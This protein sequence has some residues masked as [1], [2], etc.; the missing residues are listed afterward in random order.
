MCVS[1]LEGESVKKTKERITKSE[2]A[3]VNV[4][5]PGLY[6]EC[7]CLSLSVFVYV[8]LSLRWLRPPPIHLNSP[9]K[10]SC[11]RRPATF[12]FP[13][14]P[15]LWFQIL[16]VREWSQKHHIFDADSGQTQDKQWRIWHFKIR[17][18]NE[19]KSPIR[20][21]S[22]E[23]WETV[24]YWPLDISGCKILALSWKHIMS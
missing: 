16:A 19:D 4:Q 1:E 17:Q 12:S 9:V 23:E 15:C 11:Q 13:A 24:D 22:T 18:S 10:Y 21:R 20:N 2:L 7:L 14:V 8:C 6:R 5:L 3:Y